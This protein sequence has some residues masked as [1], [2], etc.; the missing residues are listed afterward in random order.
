[1]E[2]GLLAVVRSYAGVGI[3]GE[4]FALVGKAKLQVRHSFMVR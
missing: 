4:L 1:M 2:F 3:A